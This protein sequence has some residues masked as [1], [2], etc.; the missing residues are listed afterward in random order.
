MAESDSN[1]HI[2]LHV[3]A[4]LTAPAATGICM[5]QCKAMCCRGALILQLT[6]DEIDS[7]K[8][9]ANKLGVEAQVAGSPDRMR[10]GFLDEEQDLICESRRVL[11]NRQT[12][13]LG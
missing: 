8:G 9:Q 7:F 5:N 2:G 4:G 11:I 1:G 3:T 6:P 10:S 12:A 13:D